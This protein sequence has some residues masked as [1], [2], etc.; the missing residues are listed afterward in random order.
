MKKFN[1]LV[2]AAFGLSV[3]IA[4]VLMVLPAGA[5]GVTPE[6]YKVT[7]YKTELS[8]NG[9]D[10][11][12]VFTDATGK[13]IDSESAISKLTEASFLLFDNSLL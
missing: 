9:T 6:S 7:L 11:V 1:Y 4:F 2:A 10:F 8:T 12:T 13:E 3:V 5:T